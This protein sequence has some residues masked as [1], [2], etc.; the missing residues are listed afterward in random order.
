MEEVLLAYNLTMYSI[1][2]V[3]IGICC[4]MQKSGV[5]AELASG[6]KL[7]LYHCH[8]NYLAEIRPHE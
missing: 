2:Q 6:C 4:R 5:G 8:R 7:S 1:F 3:L